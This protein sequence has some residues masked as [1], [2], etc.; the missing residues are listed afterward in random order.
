VNWDDINCEKH[1]SCENVM[2]DE[3]ASSA[4]I[5]PHFLLQYTHKAVTAHNTYTPYLRTTHHH[6]KICCMAL[7]RY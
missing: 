6:S 7:S 1:D 2:L 3:A 5:S 4:P